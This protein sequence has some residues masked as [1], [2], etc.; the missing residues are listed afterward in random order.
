MVTCPRSQR[1]LRHF[2]LEFLCQLDLM[3]VLRGRNI[4]SG[5]CGPELVPGAL[6]CHEETYVQEEALEWLD[7]E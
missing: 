6:G 4:L 7:L 5:R 1:R 2:V 3:L